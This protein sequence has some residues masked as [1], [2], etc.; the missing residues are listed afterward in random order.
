[1][2]SP[3][4]KKIKIDYYNYALIKKYLVLIIYCLILLHYLLCK[5][6]IVYM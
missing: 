2:S 3:R 5:K 1:M 6:I 4:Y